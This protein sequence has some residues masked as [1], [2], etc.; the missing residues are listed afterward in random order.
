MKK[1]VLVP[2]NWACSIEECPPGPFAYFYCEENNPE[3]VP[4]TFLG[5]KS[6]YHTN[7]KI[8]AYCVSGGVYCGTGKVIPLV[9]K[10]EEE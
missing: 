2:D 5:F 6:Q 8:D 3:S 9:V 1:M 7:G 4:N 10:W